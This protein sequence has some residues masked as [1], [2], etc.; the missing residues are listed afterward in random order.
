MKILLIV[1]ASLL[2]ITIL[3]TIIAYS[4]PPFNKRRGD[5]TSQ[6]QGKS[7]TKR[8]FGLGWIT[9]LAAI[10]GLTM[11]GAWMMKALSPITYPI[12]ADE[13]VILS[14]SNSEAEIPIYTDK[15][16]ALVCLP[17]GI[18][19]NCFTPGDAEVWYV[20]P[21]NKYLMIPIKNHQIKFVEPTAPSCAFRILDK[22]NANEKPKEKQVA[23]ISI[24]EK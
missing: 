21:N 4:V 6:G 3:I 12:A 5:E 13:D 16:S 9:F 11:I 19:F 17:A 15:L 1:L 7:A 20:M 23:T 18:R 24:Q 10:L 2:A 14:R 22:S 8:R